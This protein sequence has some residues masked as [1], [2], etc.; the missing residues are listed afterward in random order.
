M[1]R[2]FSYNEKENKVGVFSELN[3]DNNQDEIHSQALNKY[4]IN[5]ELNRDIE[6]IAYKAFDIILQNRVKR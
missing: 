2:W 5:E 3:Y 4:L 6:D 1:E